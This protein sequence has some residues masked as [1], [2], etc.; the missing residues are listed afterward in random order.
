VAGAR[1]LG[2]A[3]HGPAQL[4]LTECIYQL[5]LL[6]KI[7]TSRFCGGVDFLK[8]TNKTKAGVAVAGACGLGPARHAPPARPPALWR[9]TPCLERWFECWRSE[10]A[11]KCWRR[12]PPSLERAP[13]LC[14]ERKP[15]P[16]RVG[17]RTPSLSRVPARVG[18]RRASER[19]HASHRISLGASESA[20]ALPAALSLFER[21]PELSRVGGRTL[22]LS[23]R[24]ERAFERAFERSFERSFE[25]AAAREGGIRARGH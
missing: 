20:A 3:N 19:W 15:E 22:S 7:S 23:V 13:S 6:I 10:S 9:R 17:W 18:R 16:S 2:P 4:D 11:L 12:R 5:V 25:R 8:L 24:V 14:L 21:A 1:G